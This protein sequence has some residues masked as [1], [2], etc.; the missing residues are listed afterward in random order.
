MRLLPFP[1]F[2]AIVLASACGKN[3]SQPPTPPAPTALSVTTIEPITGPFNTQVTI[4][5]TGFS[6]TGAANS[7][8]FNGKQATVINATS[9]T[10]VV[11]VPKGAIGST[12]VKVTSGGSTA[13]GPDFTYQLTYTVST[14]AGNGPG[15]TNGPIASSK[16]NSPY[17]LVIDASDNMY[18]ADFAN[19]QIRKISAGDVSTFAG[20][21]NGYLDA[22]GAASQFYAP[23]GVAFDDK[24]N[25]YVSD[26]G[27]SVIRKI[28]PDGTV[29]TYAGSTFGHADGPALSAKF[30]DVIAIASDAQNNFYIAEH[31]GNEIRKIAADGMVSTFAGGVQGFEDGIG[32]AAKL[33]LP[34]GLVCDPSGNL[35]VCDYGNNAIRK[36]TPAGVVTTLAGGTMGN[37]DGFG[38]NAKFN[39][40]SG[41]VMDAWGNLYVADAFNYTIRKITPDGGVTTIAGKGTPAS[42]DGVGINAAF[43]WPLGISIDHAGNLFVTDVSTQKIRKITIE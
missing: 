27:N 19:N 14:Y 18:V 38:A 31:N 42:L 41:I 22:I 33:A 8:L 15:T 29:S 43:G 11:E 25:V 37:T 17:G 30:S 34:F 2:V 1:I 20:S 36:I 32:T 24:K 10:L 39:N 16:F 12:A 21:T 7:V 23:S 40:P 13:N 5:G 9:T 3:Q 28:L 4:T 35:Y 26:F 6:S